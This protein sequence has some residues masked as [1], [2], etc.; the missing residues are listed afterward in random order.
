M[1]THITT[2]TIT[3]TLELST[4]GQTSDI[5]F[6]LARAVAIAIE[7]RIG[8]LGPILIGFTSTAHEVCITKVD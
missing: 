6:D 8:L 2:A 7:S 4:D 3:L 5:E 1:N